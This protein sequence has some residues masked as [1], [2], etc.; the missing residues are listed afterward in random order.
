MNKLRILKWMTLATGLLCLLAMY[1]NF[2]GGKG[3]LTGLMI[4]CVIVNTGL[5]IFLSKEKFH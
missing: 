1:L 5:F 3:F 4:A 2:I